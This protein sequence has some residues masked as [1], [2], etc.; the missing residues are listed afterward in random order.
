M[1]RC[2]FW[3]DWGAEP[4]IERSSMD[5]RNR[6]VLHSEH[7]SW[8]NSLT[9]DHTTDTLYWADAKLHVIES[10]DINGM[11]RRPVLTRGVYH[12]FGITVFEDRLYWSDWYSLAILS[13]GKDIGRNISSLEDGVSAQEYQLSQNVSEV[14]TELFFPTD[15]HVVHPVLQ[16]RESN[17]CEVDNGGCEYLCLLSSEKEEGYSCVCPTGVRLMED[18]KK[19]RS[20]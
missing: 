9:L 16:F 6:V 8:P 5:G 13:T 12:P 4:K 20:E 10:S 19:C 7:L 14:Y 17:P 15:L 18:R 3:T 11:N 1:C 2:L